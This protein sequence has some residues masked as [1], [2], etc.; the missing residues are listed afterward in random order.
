MQSNVFNR[1]GEKVEQLATNNDF[2]TIDV[3]GG[4]WVATGIVTAWSLPLDMARIYEI[5]RIALVVNLFQDINTTTNYS[6]PNWE[7]FSLVISM[8]ASLYSGSPSTSYMQLFRELYFSTTD[9]ITYS[10]VL[11]EPFVF[12]TSANSLNRIVIGT[13]DQGSLF[14]GFAGIPTVPGTTV[15][16]RGVISLEGV[17]YWLKPPAGELASE[18]IREE[19]NNAVDIEI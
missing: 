6:I 19:V 1:G 4:A 14:P 10:S 15:T 17:S 7:Q 18:G 11:K 16:A 5:R 12:E 9:G 3:S 2:L 8:N 13:V